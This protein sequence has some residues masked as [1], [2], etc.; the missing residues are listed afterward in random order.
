MVQNDGALSH[1]MIIR[2]MIMNPGRQNPKTF[3]KIQSDAGY[4]LFIID[5]LIHLVALRS[6]HLDFFFPK[7]CLTSILQNFI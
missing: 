4:D 1:G 7:V 5:R 6:F 2:V 3:K